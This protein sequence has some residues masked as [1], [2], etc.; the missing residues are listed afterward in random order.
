MPEICGGIKETLPAD[1]QE[2]MD[3]VES[4]EIMA[5]NMLQ[6]ELC[7]FLSDTCG[8]KRKVQ[9]ALQRWG[10]F[11]LVLQAMRAMLGDNRGTRKQ[12]ATAFQKACSFNDSLL[13][14]GV[15]HR[16]LCGSVGMAGTPGHEAPLLHSPM[17]HTNFASLNTQVCRVGL[18]KCSSSFGWG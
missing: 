2:S 12:D 14:F 9:L 11:H 16:L 18:R 13:T 6:N 17:K 15:D 5:P 8:S 10:D 3:S 1:D 7:L 4:T